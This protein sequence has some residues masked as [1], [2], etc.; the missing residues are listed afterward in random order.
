MLT[1]IY[2]FSYLKIF[3]TSNVWVVRDYFS[4]KLTGKQYKWNPHQKVAK[5]KS[6]FSPT[7]GWLNR[8]LNNPAHVF[9][10]FHSGVIS[11]SVS[12]KFIELGMDTPSNNP[13]LILGEVV[14]ISIIYRISY[15]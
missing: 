13:A 5:L 3:V 9:A 4:S 7:L 12:P 14:Y 6:K 8:A 11:R 10:V 1:E 2:I 15:S